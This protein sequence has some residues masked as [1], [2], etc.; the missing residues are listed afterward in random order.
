MFN[1]IQM[2]LQVATEQLPKKYLKDVMN[3][4]LS[5]L[6]EFQR[7]AYDQLA[8]AEEMIYKPKVEVEEKDTKKKNKGGGGG[9]GSAVTDEF[10]AYN[11]QLTDPETLCAII[12]DTQRY[13]SLTTT[14]L[15]SF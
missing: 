6:R 4:C 2:Q 10:A 12:N 8:L 5:V 13:L 9:G 3:A 11:S 1:I 7:M 14:S 15:S